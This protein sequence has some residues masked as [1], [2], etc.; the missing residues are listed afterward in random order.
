MYGEFKC[1]ATFFS[2]AL[3]LETTLCLQAKALGQ[4]AVRTI[5]EA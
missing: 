1:W 4:T 3:L 5:C 2:P